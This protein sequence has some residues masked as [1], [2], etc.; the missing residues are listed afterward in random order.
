MPK[1]AS[2]WP[3]KKAAAGAPIAPVH[4]SSLSGQDEFGRLL[5]QRPLCVEGRFSVTICPRDPASERPNQ[6]APSLAFECVEPE[7]R[8]GLIVPKKLVRR[9]VW[10]NRIKR[11]TR[12]LLRLH[13]PRERLD[14]LVRVR[15]PGP[16]N[17]QD[18]VA[19]LRLELVSAFS[20]AFG[21]WGGVK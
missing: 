19:R 9:A 12:E 7:I 8:L 20:G 10:R 13:A 1:A 11:W 15:Q 21:R 14:I 18:D 5:S 3:S 6:G 2:A 16:M 4:F 17:S